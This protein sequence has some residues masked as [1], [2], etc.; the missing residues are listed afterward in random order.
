L[1]CYGNHREYFVQ[2]IN[3]PGEGVP[4]SGDYNDPEW[5]VMADPS[6]SPDSTQI[7]YREVQTLPPACSGINPLLCYLSKEPGG[8]RVR[9]VLATLTTLEPF[10][11]PAVNT[12]LDEVPWGVKYS[13]GD[14]NP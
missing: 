7:V 4:S 9:V 3:K 14:V 12:I 6:W 13:L 2:K 5:N 11:V 1:D 10:N 8:R